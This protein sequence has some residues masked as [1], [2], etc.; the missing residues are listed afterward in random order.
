MNI[1]QIIKTIVAFL[2]SDAVYIITQIL[3]GMWAVDNQKYVLAYGIGITTILIAFKSY[4]NDK[5]DI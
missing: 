1:K 2:F 3:L 5:T 4:K